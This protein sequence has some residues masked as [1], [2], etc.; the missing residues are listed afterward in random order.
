MPL[1]TKDGCKIYSA[2]NN[3]SAVII[4]YVFFRMIK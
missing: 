2:E 4:K 3:K 1:S